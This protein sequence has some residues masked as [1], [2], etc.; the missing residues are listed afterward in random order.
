MFGLTAIFFPI[1]LSLFNK[2]WA[3]GWIFVKILSI[4]S[5]SY[6]VFVLG[7][8]H[9]FPFYRESI[10]IVIILF[11]GVGLW[12]YNSKKRKKDLL[13]TLKR[14][15]K[16]ILAQELIFFVCLTFW[17]FVR[18]FEPRI[19]G[20]EKFMDQGFV[21][22]ILRSKFFPPADMWFAGESINYYYFGHLQAA[23]LT[24]LSGLDSATT[25]NLMIATIFGLVFTGSFSL[26]S[27][28]VIFAQPKKLLTKASKNFFRLAL[29]AG[30][31]SAFLV[32]LG[33]NLHSFIFGLVKKGLYW[34]PDATR[35]IGYNPNNPSDKTIHEFP[36]YS[37]VVADLHGHMNN[38]PAVLLFLA[39]LLILGRELLRAKNE[40]LSIKIVGLLALLGFLLGVH[41][42][43]NS[44]DLPIYGIFFAGV[45]LMILISQ[46]KKINIKSVLEIGRKE[47]FLGLTVLASAIIVS[48]PFALGFNPMT[49]GIGFVM[50]RSLWWQLLVLW[51]FFWFI[52]ITFW[53]FI[54]RKVK[55]KKPLLLSDYFV[56]VGTIWATVLIFI[57]EVVYVKDIYIPEYHR[58]N[59]IFKL[60]YQSFVIYALSSGYVLW[61]VGQE[62][63]KKIKPAYFVFLGLV[64]IGFFAQLTYPF[65]AIKGYY[66][67]FS[68]KNYKG[69]SSGLDFL[70]KQYPDDYQAVLW[71]NK[72]ISDQPVLLEAVGDSYT[73][74]NRVS[75]M[76][77]LP[78]IEGW[79]VHE[80]L[81]RGGYDQPGARA[82]EVDNIYQGEDK[83]TA[84]ALLNKY[85]VSYVFIGQMEREKYSNLDEDRFEDWG[86]RVFSSGD[87][88]IYKLK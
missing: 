88:R 84:K 87:T 10:F 37:F 26:V 51:G 82:A 6:L 18:G 80:W 31:A 44:W 69:L 25:Y 81:W 67:Q 56:L 63:K 72:N 39:V 60:V 85:N 50:A 22:S 7:R 73:L 28:M 17:S 33:G 35:F 65:Y 1:S 49:D 24:K 30:F 59:T 29:L 61:R 71:L 66:G 34:Y 48:L 2:F 13:E 64:A 15:W 83:I 38:I 32:S 4:I 68:L 74:Y 86:E 23:V 40:Q 20:L 36:S 53:L 8:A 41:Y 57:P 47:L 79:L 43:T 62:L 45:L 14:N 42:M 55:R 21:N 46:T 12:I 16:L 5:V 58:A 11:A 77:G 78:T 76:T 52:A 75:A 70:K 3:K 54:V 19:E 9:I 27:N